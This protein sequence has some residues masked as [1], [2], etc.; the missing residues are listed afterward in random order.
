MGNLAALLP[1]LVLGGLLAGQGG[2]KLF[3]WFNAPVS[4]RSTGFWAAACQPG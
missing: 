4:T 3:G 2:Q 1:R